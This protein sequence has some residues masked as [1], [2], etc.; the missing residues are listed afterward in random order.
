LQVSLIIFQLTCCKM[1][2]MEKVRLFPLFNR[3]NKQVWIKKLTKM[4]NRLYAEFFKDFLVKKFKTLKLVKN[5]LKIQIAIWPPNTFVFESWYS[6]ISIQIMSQRFKRRIDWLYWIIWATSLS[7]SSIIDRREYK[8]V[9][10]CIQRLW[11]YQFN[12]FRES[13]IEIFHY[14]IWPS[15]ENDGLTQ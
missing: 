14:W 3:K 12:I 5:L 13:Q 4:K 1:T 8:K 9:I 2:K 11:G 6:W 7:W 10:W 15:S